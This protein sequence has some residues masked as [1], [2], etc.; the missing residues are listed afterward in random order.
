MNGNYLLSPD[1]EVYSAEPKIKNSREKSA[2]NELTQRSMS[3]RSEKTQNQEE[4]EPYS[5]VLFREPAEF[6]IK[7]INDDFR[8]KVVQ[9]LQIPETFPID[10][11]ELGLTIEE[12][13][14]LGSKIF[15]VFGV[16]I[17]REPNKLASRKFKNGVYFKVA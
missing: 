11:P 12:V 2:Q 17:R 3:H 10:S 1:P 15:A 4:E 16:I 5:G 14:E 8:A 7:D 13:E 6:E 9:Q